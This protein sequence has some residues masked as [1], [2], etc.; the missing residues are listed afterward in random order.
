MLISQSQT[1]TNVLATLPK[2]LDENSVPVIARHKSREECIV[3][4]SSIMEMADRDGISLEEAA[5]SIAKEHHTNRCIAVVPQAMFYENARYRDAVLESIS[6]IKMQY[7][8]AG[9]DYRI[10]KL[11]EDAIET[12]L[13]N[14]TTENTEAITELFGWVAG[15]MHGLNKLGNDV[16]DEVNS[17][18]KGIIDYVGNKLTQ[19]A[20][21]GAQS[22][23]SKE[24]NRN[25]LANN[26]SN[27]VNNTVKQSIEKAT[28][29]VQDKTVP[30]VRGAKAALTAT[31]VLGGLGAM[32]NSLTNQETINNANPG[33]AT[34]MINSLNKM[35]NVVT[36]KAN[37]APPEQQGLIS[38]IIAKIKWAI[39]ALG[40]KVGLVK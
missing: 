12:D 13:A 7:V 8:D 28:G 4:F 26:L 40:R 11:L 5:N 36:G 20:L 10:D 24:E 9:T 1:K 32:F 16:R 18:K 30:Y 6:S 22:Y 14:G 27:T 39:Q 17:H 38:K 31:A 23:L 29:T 3:N 21:S 37:Q 2:L 15:Q 35:L 34:R 33:M 25:K 19:G